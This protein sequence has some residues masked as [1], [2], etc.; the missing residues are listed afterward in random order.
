MFVSSSC[1]VNCHCFM[2][3]NTRCLLIILSGAGSGAKSLRRSEV[4]AV[5]SM[6]INTSLWNYRP[7]NMKSAVL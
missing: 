2:Q 4:I 5:G 1:D 3:L 7:D 6:H